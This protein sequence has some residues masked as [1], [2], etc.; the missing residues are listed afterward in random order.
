VTIRHRESGAGPA[1]GGLCLAAVGSGDP[2]LDR[3]G[4]LVLTDCDSDEY[5]P[6]SS[7]SAMRYQPERLA[8]E[9]AALRRNHG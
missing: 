3:T 2:G 8:G 9:I 1:I 6:A 4:R 7:T 5:F